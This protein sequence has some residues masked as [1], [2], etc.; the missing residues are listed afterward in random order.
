MITLLRVATVA[1][2]V[3]LLAACAGGRGPGDPQRYDLGHSQ[4][5][6]TTSA[7]ASRAPLVLTVEAT[8]L[9]SETGMIWRVQDSSAPQAYAH[10]RWAAPPAQLLRQRLIDRLALD[11]PVLASSVQGSDQLAVTLTAFEHV[12]AANG[13]HSMGAVSMRAVLLRK[14]AVVGATHIDASDPAPTK[15][16][17]GGVAALREASAQAAAKL[18]AWLDAQ[19]HISSSRQ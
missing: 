8:A 15:D 6:N 16:A 2:A 18:A 14:S 19:S 10:A 17:A 3:L 9:P 13:S 5:S 7:S 12:F 11:G 1:T 4:A